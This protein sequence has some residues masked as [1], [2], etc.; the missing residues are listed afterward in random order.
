[1]LYGRILLF[2]HPVYNS[3]HLL[4]P[5]SQSFPPPFPPPSNHKSV[6]YVSLLLFS[7]YVDLC[8][9]LD[10]MYKWHHMVFA[11][12]LFHLVWLSL[13]PS[14]LLQMFYSWL[15]NIPLHTHIHTYTQRLNMWKFYIKKEKLLF[16]SK[17]E[18]HS[19]CYRLNCELFWN[20]CV[21][22]LTHNVTVL[23]DGAFTEVVRVKRGPKSGALIW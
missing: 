19:V 6:L 12:L 20:S 17:R 11:F 16:F 8:H 2:I 5:N 7:R 4:I 22:G 18:Y 14:M 23:G 1:M 13:G 3:W 10:S 15:S 21:E 9:I